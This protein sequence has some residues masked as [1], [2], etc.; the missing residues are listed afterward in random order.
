[1]GCRPLA[2]RTCA[3][4]VGDLC[5]SSIHSQQYWYSAAFI[6]TTIHIQQHSYSSELEFNNIRLLLQ[7]ERQKEGQEPE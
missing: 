3:T 1:M 5:A 6:S 2:K 7:A 4:D